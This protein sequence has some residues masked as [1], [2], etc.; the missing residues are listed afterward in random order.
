M[1]GNEKTKVFI[2]W[3]GELSHEVAKILRKK[4]P[5]II[6]SVEVFFSST[7]IH[8]GE[9]GV[10]V[11][12]DNLQK[13][14]LSIVIL[15]KANKDKP[16]ILFEAGCIHGHG[17]K[18]CSL[19]IDVATEEIAAPLSQFQHAQFTKED[20]FNLLCAINEVSSLSVDKDVLWDSLNAHWENLQ[21]QIETAVSKYCDCDK[22]SDNKKKDSREERQHDG[23]DEN[24]YSDKEIAIARNVIRFTYSLGVLGGVD[25]LWTTSEALSWN[26]DY[27]EFIKNMSAKITLTEYAPVCHQYR[28]TNF[29]KQILNKL[30][31]FSEH[32]YVDKDEM[33]KNVAG[34]S[35]PFV[36]KMCEYMF[37]KR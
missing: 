7:D 32:G 9:N 29:G 31:L 24:K 12:S 15:T 19:L 27:T 5:A 1:E 2:S 36:V 16:W 33:E 30:G 21:K 3:S 4:L 6:Q 11:I 20:F 37:G 17:G 14:Q 34:L 25:K 22:G 18:F 28:I 13:S 8:K 10:Q 23:D 35:G 26:S